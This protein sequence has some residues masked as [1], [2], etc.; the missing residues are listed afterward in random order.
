MK[1][2]SGKKSLYFSNCVVCNC[3]CQYF[4]YGIKCCESC[5][6]FFRRTISLVK[7]YICKNGG[8]CEAE[9]DFASCKRCR[10]YKCLTVGMNPRRIST[11]LNNEQIMAF[12][13]RMK[14]HPGKSAVLNSV[15]S[16]DGEEQ[17]PNSKLYFKAPE[18][19]Q[20]INVIMVKNLLQ[21][22]QKVCR[23]RYSQTPVPE[24]FY[25]QCDTFESIFSRKKNLIE[26]VNKFSTKPKQAVPA[27]F[28]EKAR[29]F[30]PFC[31]RPEPVVLDLLCVFEI[32]K[33]FPFFD[34][35]GNNDKIALCSNIAM[36]LYVL[37]SSFYSVQQNCD[38]WCSPDGAILIEI[39]ANSFYKHDTIV[40]GMVDKLLR[41][42]VQTFVRLK[43]VNEEFVIIRAIIYSHMVSPGL[44]DQA[45]KLLRS[46][47]E[48]YAAL[49]MSVVQTN[50]GP[51]AGA[52]R[53]VELMGLIE[54]LFNAGAKHRQL[55]TYISN[56]LDPNFDKVFPPVLAKI[57]TKG[58]VESHQLFPY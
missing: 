41:N 35:L 47:A 43:L 50:Y 9:K 56:V 20:L 11:K 15:V 28:L 10:L 52:L 6:H 17:N 12:A 55:L 30:G 42:A 21:I 49:L 16:G 3:P 45:Q 40:M 4:Y 26:L 34:Q 48:K 25:T 54:C 58:P 23:I 33:T 1:I 22:E 8:E 24:L 31:M 44:S 37:C 53:Y 29:Q 38:V 7:E 57:C 13:E 18:L 51:A 46:E 39:F 27:I 14:E 5:R 32:G 36:P 19:K 2:I